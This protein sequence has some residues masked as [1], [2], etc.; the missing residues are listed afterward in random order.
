MSAVQ[1]LSPSTSVVLQ[2]PGGWFRNNAGWVSGRD[3]VLLVDTFATEERSRE[4]LDAVA[5]AT[6]DGG[7][8]RAVLTHAH[9]DHAHGARQVV[10]RG[11]E[12]LAAPSAGAVV[13]AG[14]HLYPGVFECSNWGDVTPPES[15]TPVVEPLRL[16]LGGIEAHVLPV[17]GT[18]HTDGDLVVWVPDDG[19]LFTGDL[20]FNGVCPLAF[21]GSVTGWAE[22]LDWLA[23]FGAA[24]LVPGH[25]QVSAA[26]E[27]LI[28]RVAEY[29]RWLLD[30]AA[31]PEELPSLA[32]QARDRYPGW[33]D[34]ERH[35]VNLAVARSEVRGTPFDLVAAMGAALAEV[36]GPI[37]LDV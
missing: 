15:T 1:T 35:V 37:R 3:G 14:P 10:E 27:D 19:V 16:D 31:G 5:G 29:L 20:L 8:L 28:G 36:G 25:G 2:L 34:A 23:G 6:P 24:T 33:L 12:V 4:L 22:A 32:A 13:A 11:G 18:A 26:E 21:S 7:S 17:P 9:G 30:V